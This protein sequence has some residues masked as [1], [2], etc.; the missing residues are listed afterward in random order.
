MLQL[1]NEGLPGTRDEDSM[2]LYLLNVEQHVDDDMAVRRRACHT[3]GHL[4]ACLRKLLYFFLW[5]DSLSER[6]T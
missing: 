4:W 1:A 2:R 3:G 6:L 5:R